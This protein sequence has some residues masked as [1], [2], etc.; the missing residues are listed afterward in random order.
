MKALPYEQPTDARRS[1][2]MRR[3]R[4]RGTRAEDDVANAFRGVGVC[5]RRNV[6]SLPGSPDFANKTRGWAVFVNGCF[7][8]H[9][10]G[11]RRATI[12]T[13][14]RAYWTRKFSE[15][16]TRDEAK[17][18]A[19]NAMGF[20]VVVIWECEVMDPASLQR[21]VLQLASR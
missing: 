21:S 2:L 13:R 7:W 4:Q 20:R 3:V 5:Y 12:P 1:E 9:H 19:L 16:K 10:D 14:N 15:N 6:K 8:H 11:C 17:K 18:D